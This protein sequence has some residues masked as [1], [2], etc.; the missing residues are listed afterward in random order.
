MAELAG[1]NAQIAELQAG[2][3]VR[4]HHDQVSRIVGDDRRQHL[5]DQRLLRDAEEDRLAGAEGRG[6]LPD[7]PRF[8]AMSRP[9]R[10]R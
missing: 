1:I 6:A 8:D 4:A 3:A 5:V 10:R 9:P 7:R 2:G